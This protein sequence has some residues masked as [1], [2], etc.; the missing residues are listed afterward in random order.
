VVRRRSN[1]DVPQELQLARFPPEA[2]SIALA[3]SI[4]VAALGAGSYAAF[5]LAAR[6]ASGSWPRGGI[7]I[8]IGSRPSAVPCPVDRR[9]RLCFSGSGEYG[10]FFGP[11]RSVVSPTGHVSGAL[12]ARLYILSQAYETLSFRA[13]DSW[14]MK[15]VSSFDE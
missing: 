2:A 7:P 9:A 1:G 13:L 14:R 11:A 15:W 10:P 5:G 8:P 4:A 12:L 3:A 6:R